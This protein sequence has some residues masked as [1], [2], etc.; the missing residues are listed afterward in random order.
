MRKFSALLAGLIAAAVVVACSD[1]TTAAGTGM[2]SVSLTDAPFQFD[3]VSRVDVFVVKIEGRQTDVD[4]TTTG[5]ASNESGW[6]TVA[7]P[8]TTI[9]LLDLRGGKTTNLGATALATG[10]YNGFRLI[11]DTDKS[12]ITLTDGTHPSI[13]WPSAAQTGVKIAL[14]SPVNLTSAGA[15]LLIDFDIGRSFVMRGNTIAGNGLL[16]KPVIL[17]TATVAATTGSVSG[18]VHGDNATGALI[19]GA[20]VELLKAGTSLTD[21]AS[22]NVVKT[23]S[24]DAFG[25]FTLSVIPAGS[26][27]LRV[28]PTA[29]SGYKP[30]LY[31][32]AVT[33]TAGQTT[34]GIV[35]VVT[36]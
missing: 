23:I 21:T 6:V 22:A 36:K 12:S 3:Q 7:S 18:T 14:T 33:V 19:S 5:N 17:G 26:Y 16:F 1:N 28:T 11:L 29:A 34:S 13:K 25:A 15:T 30:A 20:S 24:T 35:V 2:L 8:N 31:S 4:S 10:T 9:N 32:S 27:A